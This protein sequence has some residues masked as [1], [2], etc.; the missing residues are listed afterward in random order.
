MRAIGADPNSPNLR[1]RV[2]GIFKYYP[3]WS[4]QELLEARPILNLAL[5]IDEVKNRY[6]QVGGV[7]SEVYSKYSDEQRTGIPQN[8]GVYRLTDGAALK[9][10]SGEIDLVETG[11]TDTRKNA[12]MGYRLAKDDNGLFEEKEVVV[13]SDLAAEKIS[14]KFIKILWSKMSD[15]VINGPMI[16]EAYTR[17]V[18]TKKAAIHFHCR[19]WAGW[20]VQ[21][22]SDE[23][24]ISG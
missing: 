7:P 15:K 24:R 11:E 20:K 5:T 1:G 22:S 8:T 13:I 12:V 3:L 21:G 6:R 16:F 9:L 19:A 10:V 2:F 14:T 17:S 18:M 23:A 4:L